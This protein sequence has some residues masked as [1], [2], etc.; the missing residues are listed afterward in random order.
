MADY[1]LDANIFIAPYR[2]KYYDFDVAPTFWKL[3][4]QKAADGVLASPLSVYDELV[5]GKD[6]L[7][8]WARQQH[9]MPLFVPPDQSVQQ[10]LSRVAAYV[11]AKYPAAQS[12]QFLAGADAW[13][14][15]Y[16]IAHGGKVVTFERPKGNISPTPKIP[17]V[18]NHFGIKWISLFEMFGELKVTAEFKG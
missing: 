11:L 12:N 8:T 5:V 14:I 17:D 6:D 2:N 18:C 7:A 1:W 16:A 10:T 4:T 15:A 3:L 13:L 9:N